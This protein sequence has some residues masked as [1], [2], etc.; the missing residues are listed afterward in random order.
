MRVD[1][2]QSLNIHMKEATHGNMTSMHFYG[3]KQG[4]KTGMYYLRTRPA[5]DAIKFTVDTG[6]L[7]T[8]TKP[9]KDKENLK[10][11]VSG[12]TNGVVEKVEKSLIEKVVG[13]SMEDQ[14]LACSIE[15]PG[16]CD[17]CSG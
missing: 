9:I 17:M 15:N 8:V 6:V 16:A 11:G 12:K 3:W 1:Q 14:V 13:M 5:A 4:L 2:S 10:V 7:N